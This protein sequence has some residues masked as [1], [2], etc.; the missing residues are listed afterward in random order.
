MH[1]GSLLKRRNKL[2]AC[3][4]SFELSDRFGYETKPD[5]EVTGFV[6][7]KDTAAW[8]K[9]YK[10]VKDILSARENVLSREDRKKARVISAKDRKFHERRRKHIT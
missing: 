7:F 9:A 4:E 3:E 5:P 6:E 2:L 8:E 1:T 10:E